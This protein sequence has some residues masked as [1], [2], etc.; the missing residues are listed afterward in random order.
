MFSRGEKII[1]DQKSFRG[2]SSFSL[3]IAC[4]DQDGFTTGSISCLDIGDFVANHP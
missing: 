4:S 2:K 1:Y 3:S